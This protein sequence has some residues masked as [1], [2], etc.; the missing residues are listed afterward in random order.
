MKAKFKIATGIAVLLILGGIALLIFPFSHQPRVSKSL[1]EIG[2]SIS[3][4]QLSDVGYGTPEAALE[5][6][7][8][9]M[10]NTNYDKMLESVTPE[11][12]AIGEKD[13]GGRG[14][15]EAGINRGISSVEKLHILA[16]KNIADDKVEL[17]VATEQK[18]KDFTFAVVTIEQL[19]K[20]SNKWK[21]D[22]SRTYDPTWDKD[23]Q[24]EPAVK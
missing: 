23:S 11:I 19:T 22:N 24:P 14:R 3:K 10:A 12:R 5:T 16:K 9:A 17:K 1:D 8:W 6:H 15:F 4:N 20:I 21:W 7:A 13:A 18:Q 2:V